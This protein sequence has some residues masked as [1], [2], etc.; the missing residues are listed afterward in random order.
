MLE[1]NIKTN[2]PATI[3]EITGEV[4]LY[5]SPELRK[6]LLELTGKETLNIIINLE[7]VDYMDSSG[8]ATLV[9][10]LQHSSSYSGKFMLTNI[11]DGVKNVFELSRLDKVFEIHDS[12]EIA[13]KH[14]DSYGTG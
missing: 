7:K 2:G 13:L 4:D 12:L 8:V 11:R 6:A 14:I 1:I 3:V 9:E 5:S 10:G